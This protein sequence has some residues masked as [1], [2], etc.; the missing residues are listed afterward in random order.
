M[1]QAFAIGNTGGAFD[2]RVCVCVHVCTPNQCG[3][4]TLH[5]CLTL[6]HRQPDKCKCIVLYDNFERLLQHQAMPA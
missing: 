1:L 3:L 2:P 5:L 4:L 6:T